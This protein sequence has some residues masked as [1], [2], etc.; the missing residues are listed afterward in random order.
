LFYEDEPICFVQNRK[1]YKYW[2][3]VGGDVKQ[4]KFYDLDLRLGDDS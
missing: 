4:Y 2:W 3:A 1:L